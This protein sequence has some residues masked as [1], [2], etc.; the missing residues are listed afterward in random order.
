MDEDAKKEYA[1]N[2][3]K[4]C[5]SQNL[6]KANTQNKTQQ[7]MYSQGLNTALGSSRFGGAMYTAPGSMEFGGS[8]FDD[9]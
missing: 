5:I 4:A 6:N 2:M 8:Y 3:Q 7:Q 1:S 9:Y